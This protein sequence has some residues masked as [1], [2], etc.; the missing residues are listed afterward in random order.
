[1][2]SIFKSLAIEQLR[3]GQFQPRQ[4]FDEA[5]LKE[6]ASSIQTQGLIEPLI[7]RQL[8]E[9][10]YEI[11]AGERR[12][13]AAMLAG[14]K[15]VSCI[16]RNYTDQQAAAVTLI[17]NIQRADLNL[18]EE[19]LGYQRLTQEFHFSQ[20]EVAILIGKSRSHIANILRL[21]SLCDDI[22]SLIRDQQLSLGHARVLVGLHPDKQRA[23]ANQTIQQHWSV[24]RLEQ[25]VR[26][27]KQNHLFSPS[28]PHDCDRIYLENALA[29][30]IGAP[31][32][33]T[34]FPDQTGVVKIKFYNHDTLTG[35]LERMGMFYED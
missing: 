21:L 17:E 13:R 32:E 35:L 15:T 4:Q 5:G 19:A 10:Q 31:V 3:R 16:I 1:M 6:L 8:S 24:R 22:Q 9:G 14:L 26:N 23:L 29:E 2:Q 33:I 12:W 25:A 7:V 20:A 30:Y 11:I 28:I 18:I 27:R 34:S